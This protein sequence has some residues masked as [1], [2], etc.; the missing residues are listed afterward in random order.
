MS[1]II[2][3]FAKHGGRLHEIRVD[4]DQSSLVLKQSLVEATGVPIERMKVMLKSGLLKDSEHLT[5]TGLKDRQTV[6][7]IGTADP[8]PR[9]PAQVIRQDSD[10]EPAPQTPHEPVGLVNLGQTC[11]LNSSIQLI[12]QIPELQTAL[13]KLEVSRST[14]EGRFAS[15][16]R[17]LS[18]NLQTSSKPIIPLELLGCLRDIAPQFAERDERGNFAQQDADEAFTQILTALRS[19]IME[20]TD[21]ATVINRYMSIEMTK[22]QRC[23]EAEEEPTIATEKIFK[24]ECNIAIDTNFLVSGIQSHFDE[25][26]EKR[27]SAL[28][29]TALYDQHTKLSRLPAYLAVHLVRFYWRRDIGKK[30]KIMRKVVFPDR[31]DLLDLV[32]DDY[33]ARIQTVHHAAREIIQNRDA[34]G[35]ALRKRDANISGGDE[36]T[37]LREEE[38]RRLDGIIS[39]NVGV[40]VGANPTAI[41]ELCGMIT[42]KGASSDSGHYIAWTRNASQETDSKT[43]DQFDDD[44]VTPVD[45]AKVLSLNGGGE[46]SVAYILLYRPAVM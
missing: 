42:H 28:G 39:S 45:S 1:N 10:H 31:L 33:R 43:W 25:R 4:I 40:D 6:T 44:K 18:K 22:T 41:Y 24:L 29:R 8:I 13:E 27:S 12:Q 3:V 46:A 37:S 14:P 9:A 16:V 38:R 11:Y 15:S 26:I 35:A 21:V 36:E 30:A 34:R 19:G 17:T 32:T 7:V 5:S 20:D 23:V 2:T